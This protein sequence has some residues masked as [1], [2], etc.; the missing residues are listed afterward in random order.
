M[1]N[2]LVAI[3]AGLVANFLVDNLGLGPVAPFDAAAA[4]LLIGGAVVLLTWGK[5]L[6][7]VS[8]CMG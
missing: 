7:G 1:G 2:G 8:R 4:V 3:L 6:H 5:P